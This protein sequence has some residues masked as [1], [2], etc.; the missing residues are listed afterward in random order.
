MRRCFFLFFNLIV[1]SAGVAGAAREA[2]IE[3]E[4]VIQTPVS[5]FMT[6]CV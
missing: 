2:P 4:L 1:L 3:D 6:R 5:A